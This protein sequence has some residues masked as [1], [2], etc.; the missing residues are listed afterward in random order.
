MDA[1]VCLVKPRE[2]TLEFS[3]ANLPIYCISNGKVEVFK[4]DRQSIGYK[5]SPL[6]IKFTT[7]KIAISDDMSFY[8]STDGYIDQTGGDYG[9][10]FGKRR[11][12][13]LL[14]EICR[15]PFRTQREMLLNAFNEHIGDNERLDDV[16]VV[17]FSI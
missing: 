6:N 4:G 8:L 11:F 3:G 14:N 16:T 9:F 2:K 1:A 5:D 10:S 12:R 17:G 13:A 15:S 7:V